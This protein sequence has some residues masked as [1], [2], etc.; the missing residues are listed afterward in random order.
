VR[1]RAGAVGLAALAALGLSDGIVGPAWPAIR[2]DL[3]QPLAALG[4]LSAAV[5]AG[6]VVTGVATGRVRRRLAAGTYLLVG[7]TIV[8][9][10][11]AAAAALRS[12]PAFLAAAFAVGC[13]GAACDA[14]FNADAALRRGPRLMNAL[15]ASYGIGATL[16]PLLVA[17][18]FIAGSWRIAWIAAA[19][20]WALVALVLQPSRS[21]FTQELRDEERSVRP[22][23]RTLLLMVVVFFLAVGVEAAAGA[24]GATLL[25]HRGYSRAAAAAWVAAY[26]GAFTA[27][28]AALAAAGVR[29]PPQLA[30]RV[31]SVVLLGGLAL[32]FRS[33]AGLPVAGLGLAA[34][35]P[36]LT[37]LTP[38]RVGAERTTAAVGYQLAAGTAGATAVVA[39]GGV[40]AQW[41]GVGSL[42]PFLL[43]S[44]ALLAAAEV[45]AARPAS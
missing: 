45:A 10:A 39:V 17:A 13:G 21:A 43:V 16:G 31:S 11:L 18:A 36:A 6:A 19:G 33:P 44:A 8:A 12:W 41:L 35:F 34:F 25:L 20:C 1:H 3:H 7:A 14:G 32:L 28:R 42:V 26:W 30:L 24:W 9:V 37:L 15:H 2:S 40:V 4:E 5:S 29:I 23:N 27:G 22:T 38:A